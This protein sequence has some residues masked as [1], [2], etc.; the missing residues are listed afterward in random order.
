MYYASCVQTPFPGSGAAG[1][2]TSEG[3]LTPSSQ[4]AILADIV[5]GEWKV[6]PWSKCSKNCGG[7]EITRTVTCVNR[8]DPSEQVNEFS[9]NKA[10]PS[11]SEPCHPFSCDSSLEV[12]RQECAYDFTITTS[13]WWGW[14]TSTTTRHKSRCTFELLHNDECDDICNTDK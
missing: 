14:G 8:E 7:G 10:K 13:S 1:C 4:E 2:L 5:F 3:A 6:S 11:T 12:R 9:C